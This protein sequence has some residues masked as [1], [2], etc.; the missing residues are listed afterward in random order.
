MA[1]QYGTSA[2]A[3]VNFPLAPLG[4]HPIA[5]HLFRENPARQVTNRGAAHSIL[6]R[7]RG[8][9]AW[10]AKSSQLQSRLPPEVC[11]RQTTTKPGPNRSA[12]LRQYQEKYIVE[13]NRSK[14]K[15][16]SA[17]LQWR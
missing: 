17:V 11:V 9:Q 8:D 13:Q 7:R 10:G 1:V 5:A 15:T 14:I 2:V 4:R 12:E 6:G 3:G 16:W